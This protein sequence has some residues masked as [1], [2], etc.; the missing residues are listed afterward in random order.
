MNSKSSLFIDFEFIR[1]IPVAD[2]KYSNFIN[3]VAI[4]T[5][6]VFLFTLKIKLF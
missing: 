2:D 5:L 4:A 6:F 3:G 1:K